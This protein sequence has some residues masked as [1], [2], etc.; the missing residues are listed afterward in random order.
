MQNIRFLTL[1][2]TEIDD[3]VFWYQK[4]SA[5]ESLKFK[6]ELNRAFQVG[7]TIHSLLRRSSRTFTGSYS[8]AIPIL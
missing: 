3:A 5:D 6:A 4:Q 7:Q 2:E 1:A 8:Q